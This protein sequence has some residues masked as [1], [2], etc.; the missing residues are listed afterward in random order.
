M[1]SKSEDKGII[2]SRREYYSHGSI[3]ITVPSDLVSVDSV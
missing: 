1:D 2:L 3:I